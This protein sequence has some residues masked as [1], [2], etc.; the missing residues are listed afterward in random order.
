MLMASAFV[1]L[2]I[3][4]IFPFWLTVIVISRDILIMT[5]VIIC[6]IADIKVKIQPS[7]I[8]KWTT[9]AQLATV[10]TV[11]LYQVIPPEI[12]SAFSGLLFGITAAIT[13]TSGLHYI[14]MGLN[15]QQ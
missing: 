15:F 9:V 8:S 10:F 14:Y 12:P 6:T 1:T 13:I 5:G 7:L 4:E 2:T 3:L 11:L